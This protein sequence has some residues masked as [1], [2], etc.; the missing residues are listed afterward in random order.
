MNQSPGENL[1]VLTNIKVVP[2]ESNFLPRS[3]RRQNLE[4]FSMFERNARQDD[5][6]PCE[7]DDPSSIGT[8]TDDDTGFAAIAN[9]ST[10]VWTQN[11]THT[12]YNR[13]SNGSVIFIHSPF[14]SLL[15]SCFSLGFFFLLPFL[16]S[17]SFGFF[18]F[19]SS[20][21]RNVYIHHCLNVYR[22]LYIYIWRRA[23]E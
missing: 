11:K 3:R 1:F 13:W 4:Q 7:I 15:F 2:I 17:F 8:F 9:V 16:S 21:L 6:E 20:T 18:L 10:L 12:T 5:L 14:S 22:T 19:L 23:S